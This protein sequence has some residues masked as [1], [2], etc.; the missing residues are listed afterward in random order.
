MNTPRP[1]RPHAAPL[2][3]QI[4]T[5]LGDTVL[6]VREIGQERRASASALRWCAAGFG[7]L[8]GGV[9]LFAAE[10][11][12]DWEGYRAA[13]HRALSAEE[14][15]PEAPGWGLGGVGLV[16]A[17]AGLVPLGIGLRRRA[18]RPEHAFTIG[19]GRGVTLN[20][21]GE[22]LPT[23]DAFTLVRARGGA[24]DVSFGTCLKGHVLRAGSA[25]PLATSAGALPLREGDRCEL[26]HGELTF[27]IEAVAPTPLAVGRPAIDRPLWWATGAIAVAVAGS[28]TAQSLI[29]P[30]AA[31]WDDE[32]PSF[33]AVTPE[34]SERMITVMT[35]PI[36]VMI[37]EEAPPES[38]MD[39]EGGGGQRHLGEEGHMGKPSSKSKTGLYAMRGPRDAVPQLAR[40]FD[41][42]LASRQAGILGVMSR[43]SGH[44]LA[45]PYGG[46]FA[47]GNDESEI[48]GGLA[49]T[50]IGESYGVGGLGLVG[51]GHG[52]DA[53]NDRYAQVVENDFLA[54]ADAPLSTFAIDVDTAAYAN[55]RRFLSGGA[56]PPPSSVRVEEMINYFDYGDEA[57]AAGAEPLAV[58]AEVADAPWRPEHRLVR[59]GV[60]A[61]D[62]DLTELPPKN[63]VFLI[64]TSGSMHGPDRLDL[65][66]TGIRRL[67][68]TLRPEDRVSIV[69]Y[70][71]SSGIVL[72]PTPGSSRKAIDSALRNLE[73]GGGTHGAAGIW[74]AYRVA[75]EAFL[76][77]GINRIILATDGDFNVGVTSHGELIDI[78]ER[79]RK[80]GV[81]LS[82]LGVGRGNFND[83]TMEQIADHGN[84]NY[85]YLDSAEEA[86]RV[87][88]HNAAGTLATMAKDVKIQVEFNPALV[89]SYRLVGY[90]NRALA[91][92]DFADDAKDGGE[93]G[94]GHTVTALYEV[95]P[96]VA[97]GAGR[98][99]ELRYQGARDLSAAA[100]SG[101]LLTVKLRYK[102]PDGDQSRLMEVPVRDAGRDAGQ[103][104]D[105]FRLAAGVAAFGMILRGSEHVGAWELADV[106]ELLKSVK[107]SD[108]RGEIRELRELVKQ[109]AQLRGR[110][111]VR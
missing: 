58:Q 19:E 83:H 75:R 108:P 6:D 82:V 37:E 61:R 2:L 96:A 21:P 81:F 11:S 16:L 63:L 76:D 103:S 41:P 29:A 79:E 14:R 5:R 78:I 15:L 38:W 85:A 30:P 43:S 107:R 100:A 86:D 71:G 28:I 67:A 60:K 105:A 27:E 51:S 65:I 23:R 109:A 95:T 69:T 59:I 52:E 90:E 66:K 70:A 18:D 32:G 13:T 4:T 68:A 104:S 9:G 93:A 84:G 91:D 89:A 3:A 97:G 53:G 92:R 64:D 33:A 46:A 74:L 54:V 101:E 102:D 49:G 44:F 94:A 34:L 87:L 73:A 40:R 80:T 26:T 55:V 98:A 10:A 72:P 62:L 7:L 110:V 17:L 36:P 106:A 42:E 57:P 39:E 47:V 99:S 111:A 22:G 8:L 1:A 56:L 50:E 20:V 77:G 35:G 24:V 25:E 31:V 12:L 45:S 88:I 48:W